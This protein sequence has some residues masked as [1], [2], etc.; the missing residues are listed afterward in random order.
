M[1]S[2]A[3]AIT[4]AAVALVTAG[5]CASSVG[6]EATGGTLAGLR[7]TLTVDQ[8][9]RELEQLPV[10]LPGSLS[11]YR[12]EAF[13]SPWADVDTNGCSQRAD[14]LFRDAL[15]GSAITRRRGT[16]GHDVLA[17]R[18]RDPYTGALLQLNDVKSLPQAEAVQI[19]H[20]KSATS[21]RGWLDLPGRRDDEMPLT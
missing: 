2:T 15:P 4:A 13:G 1:R 17:G 12:R 16:C 8:A 18:W 21:T 7:P 5:G 11:G 3:V 10:R 20:V 6:P 9:R 14:V 19:D